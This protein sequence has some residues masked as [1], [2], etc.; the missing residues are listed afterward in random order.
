VSIATIAEAHKKKDSIVAF[1][2][3]KQVLNEEINPLKKSMKIQRG[4]GNE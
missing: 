4:E 1:R 2:D 3:M